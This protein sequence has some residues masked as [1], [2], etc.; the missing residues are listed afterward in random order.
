MKYFSCEEH[1]DLAMEHIIDEC[2]AAPNMEILSDEQKLST[3]C[4]FCEEHPTYSITD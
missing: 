4:S 1:V 2:E 3:T